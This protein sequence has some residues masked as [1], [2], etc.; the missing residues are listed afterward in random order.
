MDLTRRGCYAKNPAHV[1]SG[2]E[3]W[4]FWE[5]A[6][7]KFFEKNKFF[8]I[9]EKKPLSS[10]RFTTGAS[11]GRRVKQQHQQQFAVSVHASA[12]YP[13]SE[14]KCK[15]CSR[16]TIKK[17]E[18]KECDRGRATTVVHVR[19]ENK[20]RKTTMASPTRASGSLTAHNACSPSA[21]LFLLPFLFFSSNLLLLP[22][23]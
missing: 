21:P 9:L 10:R 15:T 1:F 23:F 20:R 22:Y 12:L 6:H 13:S 17:K 7:P 8:M 18:G 5:K 19:R 3:F 14:S 16:R 4:V 11:R 2:D